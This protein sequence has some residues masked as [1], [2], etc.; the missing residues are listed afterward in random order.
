[1]MRNDPN[2][3]WE[4][5]TKFVHS[6]PDHSYAIF[7]EDAVDTLSLNVGNSDDYVEWQN[8]SNEIESE[9]KGLVTASIKYIEK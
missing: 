9:K 2:S 5:A 6:F 4:T 8:I 7:K 3:A 1:M